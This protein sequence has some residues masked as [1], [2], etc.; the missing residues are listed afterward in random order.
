MLRSPV[1]ALTASLVPALGASTTKR[2]SPSVVDFPSACSY[3]RSDVPALAAQ[4]CGFSGLT[5]QPLRTRTKSAATSGLG[6]RS[7][8]LRRRRQSSVETLAK[9]VAQ[10]SGAR[11]SEPEASVTAIQLASR[12]H[13]ASQDPVSRVCQP[14]L[15]TH[16]L[17]GQGLAP[18]SGRLTLGSSQL[19]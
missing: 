16:M 8:H 6:S 18:S 17:F 1:Q 3:F 2:R 13:I 14:R 19:I 15:R 12:V 5:C 7:G 9:L 4:A 11:V 10:S